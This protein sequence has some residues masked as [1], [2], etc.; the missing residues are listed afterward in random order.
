[1]FDPILLRTFA[2]VAETRNFSAAG[3]KLGIRQ[4]TVSQ[5]IRNLEA[6]LD[7]RLF[8]RDTHSVELTPDG[9]AMLAHA[10]II[11]EANER[12]RLQFAGPELRGRV[13]LGAAEDFVTTHLPDVLSE[14]RRLHPSVDLEL[15]V[16]LSGML[17]RRLADRELDVILA[18]RRIGEQQGR[19]IQRERLVWA[20]ADP[21]LADP[22]RLL[23]VILFPEPS[24]TRSIALESLSRAGRAWRIVCTSESLNG[25]RAAALAGLGVSVQS[26]G[27]LLPGLRDLSPHPGLPPL[28]DI[29]YVVAGARVLDRP[30]ATLFN[31]LIDND[32]RLVA[33]RVAY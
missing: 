9:D 7:R 27:M 8:V 11:L 6:G 33:G 24:L 23:P 4:S 22:S 30:A 1:M 25:V 13:R 2:T 17:R 18:K 3:R 20:G 28:E 19:P 29:E 12:A 14:F 26:A 15:T 16:G 10:R 32:Y 31:M 21:S 5:H